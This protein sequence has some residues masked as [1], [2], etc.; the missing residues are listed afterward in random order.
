[1]GSADGALLE[2][3]PGRALS[4]EQA[5]QEG[6]VPLI[7]D[8]IVLG[9]LLTM[10]E[11]ACGQAVSFSVQRERGP[12]GALTFTC[13]LSSGDHH[14]AWEGTCVGE[15]VAQALVARWRALEQTGAKQG[16]PARKEATGWAQARMA[17]AGSA[18]GPRLQGRGRQGGRSPGTGRRR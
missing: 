3:S 9:H 12:D 2:V 6:L 10:L 18:P 16:R 4:R 13:A 14:R 11:A 8:P 17:Q 5:L 1:M 15:A 7:T